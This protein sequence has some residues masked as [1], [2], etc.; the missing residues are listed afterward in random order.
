MRA[1]TLL[2]IAL[3]PLAMHSIVEGCFIHSP[4]PVE[5]IEDHITIDVTD[6]IA[7][8]QYTC[9]FFNPNA[10]A[11]VGGTCYMEVEPGAQV[12][13][14]T[15]Q[16]EGKEVQAEILDSEK[17]KKVFQEILNRGG[18][19]ALL[20]F[21]G[22]GLIK[23]DVPRIAPHGKV[24]AVLRYT[25]ILKSE[26]G[27]FRMQVL[28][29]NPKAWIK[30]LK[31]V[32]VNATLRSQKPLK[33]IYSP[34]HSVTVVRKD[35]F[36]A[37]VSFEQNDYLPRT[38]LALYWHVAEG[39]VGLSVLTYR[40]EEERGHFMLMMSPALE[41]VGLKIPAKE[42]VF[43]I[44]TSGSMIEDERLAQVKKA[45][46]HC[47]SKLG[48]EDKFNIVT[49]ST[50]AQAMSDGLVEAGA[51][52]KR[53]SAYIE[54]LIAR[55]GTAIEEGLALS[56][57]QFT[58]SAWPKMVVFL[59]DG[60]P[61]IGETDPD[62]LAAIARKLNASGARM[63]VFG[64]GND[65]NTKLLDLLAQDHRGTCDYVLPKEDIERRVSEFY[66]KVASPVL[67]DVTIRFQDLKV[68]EVFPRRTP[69]LFKGQQIVLFGR[70]F[71]EDST[72]AP[73]KKAIVSGKID[74]REVSF[75]YT[76]SF[77]SQSSRNDFLPR[78]W[79]GRKVAFLLEEI[80][81]NGTSKEM[82]DEVTRLAK[83]Y[84]IVTPYTSYLVTQDMAPGASP[85]SFG[86][87]KSREE[88][89]DKA[90]LYS[91]RESELRDAKNGAD[92]DAMTESSSG[93][94][95]AEIMQKM[96]TIG[97]KTFYSSGGVWYDSGYDP[98]KHKELIK[99]KLL[100]DD[101][102]KLVEEQPGLARYLSLGKVVVL[103][104]GKAY[105]VVE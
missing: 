61:T 44:D 60:A 30:P 74:G 59:T 54:K 21:Y 98:E 93:K 82:V 15:L 42:I 66:E 38:P 43:C 50:E 75:E 14:M 68:E 20:E 89:G 46:Q 92:F 33:S 2:A 49:F 57:G 22:N 9:T 101:Y 28:N 40:D 63:F 13:K 78:V 18:S 12:D 7:V 65:V 16:L 67:S 73:E 80:R 85:S 1:A 76:L 3:A 88:W 72:W 23:A 79:A 24:T 37:Q 81:R 104:R 17:A 51:H 41:A 64:V 6:Q 5:L 8:K 32:T 62:R 84:G 58:N 36:N 53:A 103:Y 27:L 90:V 45:L 102:K 25:T 83:Q 34:T 96:R 55:G 35:D 105:Q 99:V 52:R 87:L 100:G 48:A 94:S 10:Q 70:Y 39:E 91:R 29:T 11:V 86:Y 77:P 95:G 56:F 19:P 4:L 26:S 47:V 69:D 31:K 71:V 97:P